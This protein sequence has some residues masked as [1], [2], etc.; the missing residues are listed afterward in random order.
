MA[1]IRKTMKISTR[2]FRLYRTGEKDSMGRDVFREVGENPQ[3]SKDKG[4]LLGQYFVGNG[5]YFNVYRD[6]NG[7]WRTPRGILSG[8]EQYLLDNNMPTGEVYSVG[9]PYSEGKGHC[10]QWHD[11]EPL[12]RIFNFEIEEVESEDT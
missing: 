8:R 4:V 11:G 9:K 1:K 12:A 5:F 2:K 6:E 3:F 7:N 10:T